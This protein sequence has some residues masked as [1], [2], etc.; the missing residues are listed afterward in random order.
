MNNINMTQNIEKKKTK[1]STE[2][3]T[4]KRIY[5]IDKFYVEWQKILIWLQCKYFEI[6]Y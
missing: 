3:Y 1:T 6:K 4:A 2:I 5:K